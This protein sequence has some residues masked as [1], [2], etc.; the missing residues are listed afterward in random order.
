[1]SRSVAASAAVKS[2]ACRS[3][4]IRSS[5]APR[6][7]AS[8]RQSIRAAFGLPARVRASRASA[9]MA[10]SGAL[11]PTAAG[12]PDGLED[13]RLAMTASLAARPP[14]Q[15]TSNWSAAC[16]TTTSSS[17]RSRSPQRPKMIAPSG[18]S[19]SGCLP[20]G[21]KARATRSIAPGPA[22]PTTAKAPRPGGVRSVISMEEQSWVSIGRRLDVQRTEAVAADPDDRR[23]CRAQ[24]GIQESEFSR[25]GRV[26]TL[27]GPPGACGGVGSRVIPP[28]GA[29]RLSGKALTPRGWPCSPAAS[30][31]REP[32]GRS[33]VDGR[34]F[35]ALAHGGQPCGIVAR[36]RSTFRNSS[37]DADLPRP[38]HDAR[39]PCRWLLTHR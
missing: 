9:S 34:S 8:C 31:G 17:P 36:D 37:P 35:R 25:S 11:C 32:G 18:R 13:V 19:A 14:W 38:L 1:M 28:A 20:R 22:T 6:A 27:C 23:A 7:P 16:R 24:Q 33:G 29:L 3:E 4:P 5:S 26:C 12:W 2:P 10:G 39:H 30:P 21:V 15:W